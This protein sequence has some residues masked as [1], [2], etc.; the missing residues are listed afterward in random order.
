LN[1]RRKPSIMIRRVIVPLAALG[2]L[3]VSPAAA[4]NPQPP[5]AES[6]PPA[7]AAPQAPGPATEIVGPDGAF[8]L[9]PDGVEW[10]R[11]QTVRAIGVACGDEACGGDRVFC[12]VQV[13]SAPEA[14]PGDRPSAEAAKRLGDGVA[15]NAPKEMKAEYLAPFAAKDLGGHPGQW[16]EL[17]AEGEP[18]AVRFGLFLL[19]AK[20]QEVAFNCVAP[21]AKWDE[22]RSRIE[23]VIASLKIER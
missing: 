17:K 7:E 11:F 20:A 18:G 8:R 1:V 4:Q 2:A 15:A 10:R 13:R 14:R 12:M 9:K 22:H 21:A 3:I 23:R 16:A 6:A 19:E 5:A